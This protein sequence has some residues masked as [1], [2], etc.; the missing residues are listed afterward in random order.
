MELEYGK[1]MW[2]RL[3]TFIVIKNALSNNEKENI[4]IMV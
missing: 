2:Y 4:S 1:H 3:K